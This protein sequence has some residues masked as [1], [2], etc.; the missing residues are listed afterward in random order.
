MAEEA[1]VKIIN[2]FVQIIEVKTTDEKGVSLLQLPPSAQNNAN[3]RDELRKP[4]DKYDWMA[5]DKISRP[6]FFPESERFTHCKH[7]VLLPK[8]Y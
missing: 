2:K 1:T 7:N 5:F 6:V 8:R 4:I 3:Y